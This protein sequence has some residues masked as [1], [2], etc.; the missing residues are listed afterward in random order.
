MGILSDV[1]VQIRTLLLPA[2]S[3]GPAMV[4]DK[5]LPLLV[6]A[7]TVNMQLLVKG[8]P[9]VRQSEVRKWALSVM[10]RT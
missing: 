7:H 10:A 9:H 1:R 6:A 8:M 2:E 3:V 5:V 4:Q